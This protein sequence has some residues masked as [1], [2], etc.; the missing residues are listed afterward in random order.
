V[1]GGLSLAVLAGSD[2]VAHETP[3]SS[4]HV[5][6]SGANSELVKKVP[7][8]KRAGTKQRVAMSLGSDKLGSLGAGDTVRGSAEVEVS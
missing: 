7:I 1:V 4:L 5:A 6:T 2:G 8:A 3:R